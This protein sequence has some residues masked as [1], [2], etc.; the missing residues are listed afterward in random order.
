MVKKS[1]IVID[2]V[3]EREHPSGDIIPVEEDKTTK[4]KRQM[5]E[6]Q[7]E[8]LKRGREAG[9]LKKKQLG[10][11]T[12]EKKKI[13]T[14]VASVKK[15]AK[16]ASIEELKKVADTYEI[17]KKI[18]SI[19]DKMSSFFNETYERRKNKEKGGISKAVKEQL[20]VI[21]SEAFVER[22]MKKEHNPYY[23][24]V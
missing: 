5:S 20:P 14:V 6:A 3:I 2:E 24:K 9:V 21:I 4:P 7:A 15:E 23:G 10:E 17:R 16:V 1:K 13:E 12:T 22:K 19:D 8:A 11:L 18:D